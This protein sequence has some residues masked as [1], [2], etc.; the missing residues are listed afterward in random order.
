MPACLACPS[1]AVGTLLD[2]GHQALSNRFLSTPD[3]TEETFPLALGQCPQCGLIQC[4]QPAPPAQLRARFDWIRYNE[5]EG[6]LDEWVSRI[7]QLPGVNR[8]TVIGAVSFKD[9]ST[10]DR[11]RALG[12][13]QTWRLDLTADF[14]VEDPCASLETIQEQLTPARASDIAAR[15]GQ[16][17][18]LIVR[19]ILEHA[20]NPR[21]F[22]H[23]LRQ[24]VT[25]TGYLLFEVPDCTPALTRGDYTMPWEEHVA[26]YTPD[27]FADGLAR[28]GFSIRQL[29][30]HPYANEN[31]LVALVQPES[32]TA[33]E[34]VPNPAL[35]SLLQLGAAYAARFEARSHQTREALHHLRPGHAPVAVFG[36]GHLSCAWIQFLK[37][38]QLVDFIVD[39]HPR[40]QGLY[41]PGSRLAIRPSSDLIDRGVRTCLSTLNAESEARVMARQKAFLDRG[42]TFASI[43]PDRPNSFLPASLP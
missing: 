27:L 35:P 5:A 12:F 1:P 13:D 24:L 19:H 25:P 42:G 39:D 16:A 17:D 15:R 36:A 37:L 20:H 9:D 29:A 31:S 34:P 28:H 26:Y 7:T 40:K 43:F 8:S 14:G 33:P 10:L 4:L 22:V 3:E 2:L 11:L 32:R 41:L 18:V 23:A 6:H 30:C 21:R 38:A